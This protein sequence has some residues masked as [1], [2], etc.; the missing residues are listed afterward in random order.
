M[1]EE[2]PRCANCGAALDRDQVSFGRCMA[3]GASID[4][5]TVE[6]Y[7]RSS[8]EQPAAA[9]D[10]PAE[11]ERKE[12]PALKKARRM[13]NVATAATIGMAALSVAKIFLKRRSPDIPWPS[14]L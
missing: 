5:A 13:N 14:A 3:C 4:P 7:K 12:D 6:S 11:Q 1:A 10:V 9:E 2:T 8:F